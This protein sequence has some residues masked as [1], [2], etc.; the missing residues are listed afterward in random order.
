[1]QVVGNEDRFCRHCGYPLWK[2]RQEET[3]RLVT[4]VFSDLSGYSTISEALDPG[5]LGELVDRIFSSAVEII[6]ARG[7]L[8][9]KFIGDAIV[10][11][12]GARMTREDDPINAIR[13]AMEVHKALDTI[14]A[15]LGPVAG[16]T[17]KM[18]T[19]I[20]A[21]YVLLKG[22]KAK[23]FSPK[24]LGSPINQASRLSDM[25]APGEILIG[26]A[27]YSF[28]KKR[29]ILEEK[30]RHQLKGFREDIHVYRVVSEKE[31]TFFSNMVQ[32]SSSKFIGRQK[33][34]QAL[35][36]VA[37]DLDGSMGTVISIGGE[38]GIG[39]TRLIT[40]CRKG[41]G[42]VNW[43]EACC[44]QSH[45][46]V[47]YSPFAEIAAKVLGSGLSGTHM[48]ELEKR[49][50]SITGSRV[51]FRYLASIMGLAEDSAMVHESPGLWKGKIFEAFDLLIACVSRLGKTV[52]SIED[53][54]WADNS[55]I[56][57]LEFLLSRKRKRP[58]C[59]FMLSHR[60]RLPLP[61]VDRA[62]ELEELDRNQV[63]DMI[64]SLVVSRSPDIDTEVLN[65]IYSMAGGNPFYVEELTTYL[66]DKGMIYPVYKTRKGVLSKMPLTVNALVSARLDN[67]DRGSRRLL[68]EA[69]AMANTFSRGL[70]L[71]VASE[72]ASLD[73]HINTLLDAGFI[74][75]KDASLGVYGFKHELAREVVYNSI[76]RRDRVALHARI[77][78]ALAASDDAEKQGLFDMLAY[79]YRNGGD[80]NMALKYGLLAAGRHQ[81]SGSLAEAASLYLTA[82]RDIKHAGK[83][84]YLDE[85]LPAIWEGMWSCS[86]I[87]NPD[88]AI[89]ALVRLANYYKDKGDKQAGW[90]A[91]L[92]LV[93][94][95]SQKGRFKKAIDVFKEVYRNVK[96]ERLWKA[97]AFTSVAYTHTYLG[98]PRISLKYLERA[99]PVFNTEEHKFFLT[100]NY[101]T[102]LAAYVWMA[103]IHNAIA[104]H[105]KTRAMC[106]EERDMDIAMMADIWLGYIYYLTGKPTKARQIFNA[107]DEADKRMGRLSGG[108][109][110]IR[111]QSAIYFE[112]IYM[113]QAQV[114][115]RELQKFTELSSHFRMIGSDALER[116]YKAW[117]LIS[118]GK[119][120]EAASQLE[121]SVST[122]RTGIANR[123]PYAIN[124]LAGTYMKL[125]SLDHA[126]NLVEEA[127]SWNLKNG[128]KDQLIWS[129]RIKGD[130]AT[131]M[132][133]MDMAYGCITKSL[134]LS[135]TSGMSPHVAWSF[136]S[137]ARLFERQG[138]LEKADIF[139][140]KAYRMWLGMSNPYQADRIREWSDD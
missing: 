70:L 62:I 50:V 47:P 6:S 112:S 23:N 95:Y 94:V 75:V 129:W 89:Y 49:F 35:K 19:G 32:S 37:R 42:D 52:F 98:R 97:V 20:N 40:E 111:M 99:R 18:H 22:I 120:E 3:Q 113:G 114:A 39:K 16:V 43:Y 60:G 101:I 130:I 7:G 10:A 71:D 68:Q 24:T 106:S 132:G 81:R 21:G 30:G 41:L 134:N 73:E 123:F 8:V 48:E 27:M 28:A 128:N 102:T 5:D 107:C 58:P 103:D 2:E 11:L 131:S 91:L 76:L 69:S 137:L 64:V 38:A 12:F 133:D 110:Y 88:L 84:A 15:E 61:Y 125:G 65:L 115:R 104:W 82:E 14:A 79:H 105:Q 135:Q 33:Q 9:E 118:E 13:A 136:A 53:L 56:E 1:M 45:S 26:D 140:R 59:I 100:A 109:S 34:L 93:N 63:K 83:D 127:L 138:E 85:M 121:K 66:L 90:F 44:F 122:L 117:I 78:S 124:A 139:Y 4:V 108:L 67:L 46:K 86:R 74:D 29:F 25:A 87:V 77:A 36:E 72:P 119:L 55:S 54:H 57:L 116:L 96:E 17:L 92:R 31:A 51:H 126:S 80:I